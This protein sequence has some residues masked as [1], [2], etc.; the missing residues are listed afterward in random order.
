MRTTVDIPDEQ[1]DSL[2]AVCRRDTISRAEAMRR[3]VAAYLEKQAA[4]T[5]DD[6][7]AMWRKRKTDGVAYQRKLRAEWRSARSR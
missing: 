6:A 3:A 4:T 5:D 2:A 7:F 1:L